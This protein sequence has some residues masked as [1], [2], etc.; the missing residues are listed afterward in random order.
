MD[1]YKLNIA[2]GMDFTKH[3]MQKGLT[4]YVK[5]ILVKTLLFTTVEMMVIICVDEFCLYC[6]KI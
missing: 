2:Q 5:V 6:V 1:H 4:V 3:I